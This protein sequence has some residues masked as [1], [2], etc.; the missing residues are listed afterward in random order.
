[1][2]E[3]ELLSCPHSPS[4]RYRCRP[5]SAYQ[6]AAHTA[7]RMRTRQLRAADSV[8]SAQHYRELRCVA[9]VWLAFPLPIEADADTRADPMRYT[10]YHDVASPAPEAR[11]PPSV[12]LGLVCELL[13]TAPVVNLDL[14][15]HVW[16]F[17][18]T[19]VF[20]KKP[21]A[22]RSLPRLWSLSTK[23][24]VCAHALP[25]AVRACG[26]GTYE[27]TGASTAR[28]R[29]RARRV[30]RHGTAR[31]RR[32]HGACTVRGRGLVHGPYAGD[33]A[34]AHGSC[35]VRTPCAPARG[36][37]AGA[38]RTCGRARAGMWP[39]AGAGVRAQPGG[40]GCRMAE[41]EAGG[42]DD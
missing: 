33:V 4:F 30:H 28:A 19:T 26:H 25:L 18:C 17:M 36:A 13:Y 37:P 6:L 35:T 29:A 39:G 41:Y 14:W 15:M 32:I 22:Q 38:V 20:S 12:A 3:G 5:F 11:V 23:G 8:A 40:T 2:L 34:C 1:M 10:I 9:R 24:H 27:W 42:G 16:L 31:T 7:V 21:Y